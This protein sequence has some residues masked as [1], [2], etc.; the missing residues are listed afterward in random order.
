MHQVNGEIMTDAVSKRLLIVSA[1][2]LVFLGLYLTSL[3]SYLFFHSVA[4]IFSVVVAFGIF[5]VVW[6][7]RRFM[8]NNYLS[9]L[10]VAYLFIGGLDL[11]HTLAYKGMGV[12]VGHGANLATQLWIAARYLESISVLIAPW[13][14]QKKIY[15]FQLFT[16]YLAVFIFIL[17]S[18]FYWN[19][20]PVCYHEATGLTAFKIYSEYVI[21]L[22]LLL[23]IAAIFRKRNEFDPDVFKLIIASIASTIGAEL[24]FTIYLN[25]Y[26]PLNLIGHFFKII[27]FFLIYRAVIVTGLKKPYSI[28]FRN[29]KKSEEILQVEK[30]RLEAALSQIRTLSGLLPICANCKKI[31]DDQGYWNQIEA[32]IRDHS[33]AQFSHSICPECVKKLY[34]ELEGDL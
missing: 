15:I 26:G 2:I 5:S 23:S 9:V 29:L 22:M 21:C 27:S 33:D 16:C 1:G 10:G 24:A 34:P 25:V 13:F 8:D 11:L 30:N 6:N 19:I 18:I 31:R 17:L 32:Y 3:Y 14:L 20:F 7:A 28:M 4:E 12:F